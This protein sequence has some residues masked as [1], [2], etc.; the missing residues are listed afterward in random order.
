MSDSEWLT[1]QRFSKT[2]MKSG[3][4]TTKVTFCALSV[5]LIVG[6]VVSRHSFWTRYSFELPDNGN[7]VLDVRAVHSGEYQYRLQG[8]Y[9]GHRFAVE[10]CRQ[11][12]APNLDL[13]WTGRSN[14]Y[15]IIR[16]DVKRFSG[17]QR[18]VLNL[19]S[20]ILSSQDA[21]ESSEAARIFYAQMVWLGSLDK[22]C[23]FRRPD[24]KFVIA[25][26]VPF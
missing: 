12:G 16:H 10:P 7:A 21:P 3:K 17:S 13:E 5:L 9:H 11:T 15:I 8:K 20:G 6:Y 1:F 4:F 25:E 26:H 22:N 19:D 2:A 18:E 14:T 23:D 24:G